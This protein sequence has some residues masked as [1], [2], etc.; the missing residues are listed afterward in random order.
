MEKVRLEFLI[1]KKIKN[2]LINLAVEKHSTMTTEIVA[3]IRKHLKNE[4]I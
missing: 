2:E 4:K 1:D 3:A